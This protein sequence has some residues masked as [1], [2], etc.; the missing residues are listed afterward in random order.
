MSRQTAAV[1]AH[2]TPPT[3]PKR[4]RPNPVWLVGLLALATVIGVGLYTSQIKQAVTDVKAPAFTLPT[5]DGRTVSLADYRGRNVLLYF[6]EG[7]GCQA[8]LVQMAQIEAMQSQFKAANI[9]VLPIVMNSKADIV[10]DMR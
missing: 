9:V 10:A 5:T 2:S 6:S 7:A 1:A 4:A 8:C 3:A